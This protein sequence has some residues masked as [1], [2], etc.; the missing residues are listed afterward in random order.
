MQPRPCGLVTLQPEHPLRAHTRRTVLLAGDP[1]RPPDP[2]RQG[3]AR[4]LENRPRRHRTLV[5]ATRALQKGFRL[6]P[7]PPPTATWAAKPVRPAELKQIL[8]AGLLRREA[9]LKFEQIPRKI[10][11]RRPYYRL[12][13]PESS[14]YPP[15]RN[16]ATTSEF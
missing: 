15:S 16:P 4:I 5:A 9:S 1:P 12:W 13:L 14:K 3:L 7:T 10:L 11:H 8:P 2:Q 6:R